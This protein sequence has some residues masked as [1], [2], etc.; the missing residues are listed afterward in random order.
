LQD[1]EYGGSEKE[2]CPG[3]QPKHRRHVFRRLGGAY[4]D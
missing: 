3:E 4:S 2:H 1:Q